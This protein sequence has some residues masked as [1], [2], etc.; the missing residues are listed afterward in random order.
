MSDASGSDFDNSD[1]SDNSDANDSDDDFEVNANLED[2]EDEPVI[3]SQA[4]VKAR[5]VQ[6][7]LSGSLQVARTTMVSGL[8]CQNVA[9]VLA[10]PFKAPFAGASSGTSAELARRLANRR[11][12]VPWGS[13]ANVATSLSGKFTAPFSV[14]NPSDEKKDDPLPPG[15]E[16]LVL[17]EDAPEKNPADCLPSIEVDHMLVKWLRPHQR[18]GVKFMFE[19]VE[20]LR[21]FDGKGCIL[22]DDMGL[23]KTLQG[24]A[25][26][27]TLLKQGTD[28]KPTV[29]RALI[30]CPTSLVSNWD[31]ECNKWLCGRVKT[32][33][34]CGDSRA[35]VV[36][37]VN[38]FLGPRNTAQV[39]IIS[40]ETFRIHVDKFVAKGTDGVQLVMCDEA[41]RLKN[42]DTLTNKALCA[43]PC[44][45]RVML[46]GTP[47]QNHLD[48]F[49]AMVGFCN[50]G[51][52]GTCWGFPTSRH[53]PFADC[54]PVITRTHGPKD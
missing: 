13:T 41:H 34:V 16:P 32:L 10:R 4:Q 54:P 3:M 27:W 47:M 21:E 52:L 14:A 17:W 37:S 11:R 33:P 25:L 12:F 9:A 38:R 26:L 8:K 18:E 24:I 5:N 2:D 22:A 45:R 44:S 29:N 43:V 50:P 53:R 28:G 7:M 20:V 39:M 42:G 49:Y 30:V 51:L 15:I 48:E 31:D 40:Y 23:G 1:N 19:C 36:S 46:S 6:Q 35:D